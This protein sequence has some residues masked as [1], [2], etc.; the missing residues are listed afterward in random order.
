MQIWRYRYH[1][2]LVSSEIR[3]PEWSAF[4]FTGPA[5]AA[6]ADADIRVESPDAEVPAIDGEFRFFAKQAGWFI[7]R[8][9]REIRLIPAGPPEAN[10]AEPAAR[11][12]RAFLLGSAWGALLYQRGAL[13]LHASAVRVDNGA[14]AFCA[15]RGFGK[16]TLAA[17]LTTLGYPLMSDDLCCIRMSPDGPRVYPS[18][19]RFR[20]C[21]DAVAKL[22]WNG[23]HADFDNLPTGKYHH[24][25][26]TPG[27]Q[28]DL[29]LLRIYM[30]GWGPPEIHRIRGFAALTRLTSAGTWR[31][32]MLV[33]TGDPAGHFS[34]CAQLLR[35][36]DCFEFRRPRDLELLA[37]GVGFLTGHFREQR[38]DT[39][40]NNG[41]ILGSM[42]D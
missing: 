25:A 35:E 14:I 15:R 6:N 30:L 2:L 34:Q 5:S 16:S 42:L 12:R 37:P 17:V 23:T 13:L 31:G 29:P 26:A 33:R 4:E 11:R 21:G 9:G 39:I 32:A 7:V 8:G 38:R 27:V 10:E 40:I 36:V 18:I 20:L 19:P 28:G 1:G 24:Y 3:L 22:G 41:V